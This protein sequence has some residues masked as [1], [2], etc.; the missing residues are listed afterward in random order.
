MISIVIV[1]G[2]VGDG[3]GGGCDDCSDGCV[4]SDRNDEDDGV[5]GREVGWELGDKV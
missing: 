2:D 4:D 1:G 3:D 5:G